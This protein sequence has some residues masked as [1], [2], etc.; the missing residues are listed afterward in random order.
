MKIKLDP[1]FF[2]FDIWTDIGRLLKGLA[3]LLGVTVFWLCI[4]V[5]FIGLIVVLFVVTGGGVY[6]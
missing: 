2:P 4:A 5:L 3:Y 6:G 1:S